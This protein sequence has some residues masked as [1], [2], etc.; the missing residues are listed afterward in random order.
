MDAE[1]FAVGR[2]VLTDAADDLLSTFNRGPVGREDDVLADLLERHA[3][4]DW[5]EVT[6]AT[7]EANEKALREGGLR[8]L[9]VYHLPDAAHVVW[10]VTEPDR[11]R[12]T[13]LLPDDL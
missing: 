4:G 8:L 13:F 3:S 11:S 1:L 2:V 12:T 10:V 6:P 7:A 9:S 5:G